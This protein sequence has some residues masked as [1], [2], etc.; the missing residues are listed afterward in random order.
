M[1]PD[2][3]GL[4]TLVRQLA[5]REAV[6]EVAA[7]KWLVQRHSLGPLAARAGARAFRDDLIAAALQW[8]RI[9]KEL[10]SITDALTSAGIRVTAIK[11]VAYARTL[12]A[13]G[14]ERPMADIDLLVP[15]AAVQSARTVLARLGFVPA[16][17]VALHHAHAWTR[18][19]LALDLHWNIIGRGRGRVD[20]DAVWDRAIPGSPAGLHYLEPCDG[21]AFHLI[22]LARNRLRLPLVNV[23][24]AARLLERADPSESLGRARAWGLGAAAE[25]ALRFCLSILEDRPGRPAGWLGPSREDITHLAEETTARKVLFDVVTA[26]SPRQLTSRLMHFGANRLRRFSNR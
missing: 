8:A 2:V 21:L 15:K 13:T 22:H 9:E 16:A 11:G 4:F 6:T 23:V 24:D 12:Y 25:L 7:P 1:L 5:G 17:S 3:D 19:D 18:G 10:P 14:A 20:L 26:G